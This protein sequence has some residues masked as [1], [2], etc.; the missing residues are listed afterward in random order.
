MA[1]SRSG[2]H[3]W[4]RRLPCRRL[5]EEQVLLVKIK[6]SF[7]RSKGN[8]G[9]PSI[10]ADL[11]AEGVL[12]SKN[13][14]AR[15]MRR[16]NISAKVKKRYVATTDSNHSMPVADN[17]LAQNFHA[18]KI[19]TKWAC[20]ITYIPTDEGWLYLAA[21]LDLS[22]RGTV[23]WSMKSRM[24]RS[25]V[26]DAMNH[27]LLNR[28]P[29]PGLICHSDR[30]SQY[31]SEDYQAVLRRANAICS[32]SRK[33]NCYDNAPAES[34][35]ATLKRELVEKSKFATRDEARSAVFTWIATWYNRERRHSSLGYISPEE[36]ET[37]QRR[38]GV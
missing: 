32:M 5:L 33:G 30:G 19:N 38:L 31:A 24:D 1:V 26:I 2:Y 25:L 20:D 16:H 21:V 18:D 15:I 14:V 28:R 13:R 27:A 17:V 11:K 37:N 8:Y 10:H 6:A 34:F 12:C 22:S 7:K 29:A 23:G 9:S 4:C 36:F 3:A 35:F